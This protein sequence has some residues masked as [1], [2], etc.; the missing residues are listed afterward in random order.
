MRAFAL[1]LA[2]LL[3][4]PSLGGAQSATTDTTRSTLSG[5][6]S[7][8]QAGKG[9][10]VFLGQCQSCHTTAD[11]TSADFRADWVGKMLSELFTFLKET[12]PES[13]PGALS[14][15]Q[16]A[17]VTSYILQLNGL[18][19]GTSPLATTADSLATIK[20]EVPAGGARERAGI[21]TPRQR[22]HVARQ[23]PRAVSTRR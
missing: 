8:E 11:L 5:V 17:A 16:Y 7:E 2:A 3:C 18:P 22:F 10:D 20:F 23:D 1:P 13:E 12:M 14:N 21:T 15:E 19:A 9:K 6:Y 4:A